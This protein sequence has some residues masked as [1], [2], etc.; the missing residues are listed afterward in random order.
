MTFARHARH[1]THS[2]HGLHG[3]ENMAQD[4]FSGIDEWIRNR[5]LL[6]AMVLQ[7]AMDARHGDNRA[8]AWLA[9]EAGQIADDLEMKPECVR[10]WADAL[11]YTPEMI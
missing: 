2:L 10:R 3:A 6:A 7:A 1:G 11:D 8:R 9:A 5:R 4:A